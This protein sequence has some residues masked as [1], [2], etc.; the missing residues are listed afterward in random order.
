MANDITVPVNLD[1]SLAQT[2]INKLKEK[3][4]ELNTERDSKSEIVKPYDEA[5]QKVKDIEKELDS[6]TDPSKMSSLSDSLTKAVDE[7][8][9]IRESKLEPMGGYDAVQNQISGLDKQIEK[10]EGKIGRLQ[11]A[12][13]R[14]GKEGMGNL[15][16]GINKSI[17]SILNFTIGIGSLVALFGKLKSII[18][19][20]ITNLAKYD[21]ETRNSLIGIK[22]SMAE[23]KGNITAAFAGVLNAIAPVIQ[24]IITWVSNAISKVTELIAALSGKSSFKKAVAN[25]NAIAK[26]MS[27]T[28]SGAKDAKKQLAGFDELNVLQDNQSGGGSTNSDITQFEDVPV[29]LSPGMEKVKQIFED[30]YGIVKNIWEKTQPIREFLSNTILT[31]LTEVFDL[32][33]DITELI[34]GDMTLSEFIDQLSPLQTVLLGIAIAIG[35]IKAYNFIS[36]LIANLPLLI[37]KISAL[38]LS[39]SPATLIIGAII[40]VIVLLLKYGDVVAAWLENLRKKVDG[41]IDHIRD[42]VNGFF[43]NIID[44]FNNSNTVIGGILAQVISVFQIAWN[45]IIGVVKTAW[46]VLVA[47]FETIATVI[48]AIATGEWSEALNKLKEIWGDVWEGMKESGKNIINSIIGLVE[49]FVNT[50]IKGVNKILDAV[51][52]VASVLGGQVSWRVTPVSFPRLARGGIVDSAT[53]FIAGEAGKEA[54]IPLERNTEWI[55]LVANGLIDRLLDNS[56]INRIANA[57]MKIPMPSMAMG[58]VVP[59]RASSSFSMFSD[60]DIGRIVSGLQDVARELSQQ[61]IVVD[62]KLYI[63]KRQVGSAVTEYQREQNRAKGG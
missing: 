14:L 58:G 51:D 1:D 15:T 7:A 27:N 53:P 32:I 41:W 57:F 18:Q 37:E 5:L 36:G 28:A 10:T 13:T 30:I 6:A 43:Q 8:K 60:E 42:S 62:S 24:T 33:Y 61:P 56:V 17:K 48:R 12:Q 34:S 46:D 38:M 55:T 40:V 35:L 20:G 39:I 21:A 31:L 3:L 22:G 2:K 52:F 49:N 4:A 45:T 44:Y 63:D 16:Q 11:K 29:E 26:G 59:P 23:L 19:E 54:V 50:I 25:T 47:L 9:S